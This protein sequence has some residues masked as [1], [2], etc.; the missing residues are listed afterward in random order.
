VTSRSDD[1]N[2]QSYLIAKVWCSRP[3]GEAGGV[4]RRYNPK[5]SSNAVR[6]LSSGEPRIATMSDVIESQTPAVPATSAVKGMKK[7]GDDPPRSAR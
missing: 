7:N 3:I 5:L 4:P 6:R 2:R 1:R